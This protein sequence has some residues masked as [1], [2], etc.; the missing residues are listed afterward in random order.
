MLHKV[1]FPYHLKQQDISTLLRSKSCCPV[2]I[3][4]R[5]RI[6]NRLGGLF[7]KLRLMLLLESRSR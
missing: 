2:I 3:A 7:H 6:D 1:K 4:H 5:D